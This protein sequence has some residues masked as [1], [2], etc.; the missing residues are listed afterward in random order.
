[1][2]A[3]SSHV[4]ETVTGMRHW[5]NQSEVVDR[6]V[7][8]RRGALREIWKFGAGDCHKVALFYRCRLRLFLKGR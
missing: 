3:P 8:F 6:L 1:M 7:L 2:K 4:L 5:T